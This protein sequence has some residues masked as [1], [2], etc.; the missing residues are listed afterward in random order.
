MQVNYTKEAFAS[1]ISLVNFIEGKNTENA[2]LRW[3]NRYEYFL[4]KTL[5][6]PAQIKLCHNLT[7]NKLNL[8]C[9]YFNDWVIAFSIHNDF[10]LVEALLH[11]SR[12]SD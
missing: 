2:G 3:L 8:R 7:F 1:L 11:K 12:I 4:Q 10:V 6:N 9:I 5:F